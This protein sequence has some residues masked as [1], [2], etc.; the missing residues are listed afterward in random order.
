MGSFTPFTFYS[1]YLPIITHSYLQIE[2]QVLLKD[3]IKAGEVTAC[4]S[5]IYHEHS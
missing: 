2:I 4:L 5:D 3:S 1:L